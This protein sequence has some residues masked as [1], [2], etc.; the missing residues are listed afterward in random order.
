MLVPLVLS[1]ASP[2]LQW[3]DPIYILAGFAGVVGMALMV[4]QPLLVVGAMPDAT[5]AAQ[6]RWHRVVGG[7]LLVAVLVHIGGLW[8]TSPPDV[9]DVLLFRSPTPFAIW[10]ALAMWAVFFAAMLA[11]LRPRLPLRLWRW[12]HTGAVTLVV[13]G[14][15]LHAV[16]IDGTMETISKWVLS[17]AVLLTLAFAI[18]RRRIWAMGW[19]KRA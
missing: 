3:R 5:A 4:L 14:T 2:L 6:R 12:A 1:T 8:I 17:A 18:A 19:R 11:L 9:V 16:Q 7:I 15:V 13:V 10:G